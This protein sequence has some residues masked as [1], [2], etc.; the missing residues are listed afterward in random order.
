MTDTP[1]LI[2]VTGH[3]DLTADSVEIAMVEVRNF[4]TKLKNSLPNTP[5]KLMSGLAD[6]ADRLV[7]KTALE[8]GI[9]VQAV[10]PMPRS[11]YEK[12]FSAES[13]DDFIEL[14]DSDNVELIELSLP[15]SMNPSSAAK[16]GAERDQLYAQ[17]GEYLIL[18]SGI[19][20]AL[21]DGCN[22]D[23]TGGT[24]DVIL[25]YLNAGGAGINTDNEV[26]FLDEI[27]AQADGP[28]FV[29]WIPVERTDS[30]RSLPAGT[31]RN[32]CYLSG[33]LGP[34]TL[35][36]QMEMPEELSLQLKHHE[37]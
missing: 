32:G 17:L 22:S 2:G 26:I 11:M 27:P 6:G 28:E 5:L 35:Y 30:D 10:L 34:N 8:M 20:L 1:L 3:R 21:W 36:R 25:R 19:L 23:L 9:G 31:A 12:D 4:F 29:Y 14:I 33:N 13:L 18:R 16:Y 24:S 7:A 15:S 37:A